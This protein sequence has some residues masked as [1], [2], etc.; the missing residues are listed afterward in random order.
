MNP[1][2]AILDRF[3][4]NLLELRLAIR[5]AGGDPAIVLDT[6]PGVHDFLASLAMNDI[7]LK[8]MVDPKGTEP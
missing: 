6:A 5:A 4:R 3:A 7:E 2:K 8:A 1:T